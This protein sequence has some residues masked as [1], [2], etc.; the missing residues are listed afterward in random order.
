MAHC[1]TYYQPCKAGLPANA[2]LQLLQSYTFTYINSLKSG[3]K[4]ARFGALSL[5]I[6]TLQDST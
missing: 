6:A 5:L 3:A 2:E 4:D 1:L